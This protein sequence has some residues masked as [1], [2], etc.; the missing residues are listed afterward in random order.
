MMSDDHMGGE[1]GDHHGDQMG[2][3]NPVKALV[4]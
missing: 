2:G 4:E 3:M 1:H